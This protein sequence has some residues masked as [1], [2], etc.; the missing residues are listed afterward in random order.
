M[1]ASDHRLSRDEAAPRAPPSRRLLHATLLVPPLIWGLELLINYGLASH[2]C[3]PRQEQL[4]GFYTGW[5]H[6][7]SVLLAL[8]LLCLAASVGMVVL[9]VSCWRR[10]RPSSRERDS[11]SDVLE[12]GEGRIRVFAAAGVLVAV[13]FCIAV[14]ANTISL[15]LLSQ[16]SFA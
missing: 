1:S 3:Y 4:T 7:W 8:N 2:A 10:E 14:L 16:C 15:G 5:G 11:H 12:P 6:A 13:L 9:S